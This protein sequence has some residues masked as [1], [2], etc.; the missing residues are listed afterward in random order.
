[1]FLGAFERTEVRVGTVSLV[2]QHAAGERFSPGERVSVE[3]RPEPVAAEPIDSAWARHA[4]IKA[5]IRV[6]AGAG[7][8]QS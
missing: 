7:E 3:I 2:S 6:N 4:T 8:R 5:D 1:M